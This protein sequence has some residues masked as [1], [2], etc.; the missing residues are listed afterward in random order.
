[1]NS[2]SYDLN[3]VSDMTYTFKQLKN[4][5]Q[6]TML[7]KVLQ[8]QKCKNQDGFIII[9][10]EINDTFTNNV[11]KFQGH[12]ER[13]YNI[14]MRCKYRYYAFIITSDIHG[15]SGHT[16]SVTVLLL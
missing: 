7:L 16:A 13:N 14:M 10:T 4:S 11:E 6:T 9:R 12:N 8:K 2:K 5:F 3:T 15:F 1:M